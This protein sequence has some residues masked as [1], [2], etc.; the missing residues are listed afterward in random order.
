MGHPGV[1]RCFHLG[2]WRASHRDCCFLQKA[3]CLAFVTGIS[4]FLPPPPAFPFPLLFTCAYSEP[5][6]V[7]HAGDAMLGEN[8]STFIDLAG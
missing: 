1:F 3:S 2:N 7:P 8:S 4:V 5:G 6:L